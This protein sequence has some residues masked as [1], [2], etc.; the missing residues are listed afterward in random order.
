MQVILSVPVTGGIYPDRAAKQ[1]TPVMQ[2][3]L[4][5]P[6]TGGIYPDRTA[7]QQTPVMQVIISASPNAAR[8]VCYFLSL[9]GFGG[10]WVVAMMCRAWAMRSSM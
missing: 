5:V 2:V 3:I 8:P 10:A 9:A 1:Q 7:R 4:S 6:V